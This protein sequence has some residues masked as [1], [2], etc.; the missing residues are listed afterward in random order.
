MKKKYKKKQFLGVRC[1]KKKRKQ[2]NTFFKEKEKFRI[3][4]LQIF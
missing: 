3:L 2:F 1:N 4:K